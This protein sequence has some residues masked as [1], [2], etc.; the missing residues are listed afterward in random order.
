MKTNPTGLD[1]LGNRASP[2]SGLA[3]L[4][5]LIVIDGDCCG[6]HS[7]GNHYISLIEQTFIVFKEQQEGVCDWRKVGQRGK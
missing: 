7:F 1:Q 6:I 4:P 2:C 5:V 3:E